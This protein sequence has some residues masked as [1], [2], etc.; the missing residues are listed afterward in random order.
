MLSNDDDKVLFG[1]EVTDLTLVYSHVVL[2]HIS[3]MADTERPSMYHLSQ[4]SPVARPKGSQRPAVP[5]T[6]AARL[7][8]LLKERKWKNHSE[9]EDELETSGGDCTVPDKIHKKVME[10]RNM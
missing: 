8:A 10:E 3:W 6:E 1:S 2:H 5:K 7:K 4:V 9:S